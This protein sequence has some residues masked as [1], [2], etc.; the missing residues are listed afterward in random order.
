M[1]EL[2]RIE[3]ATNKVSDFQKKYNVNQK[4]ISYIIGKN[5]TL[6]LCL[7]VPLLLIGTVWTEFGAI[8]FHT[9]MIS[10]GIVT[11]MLLAVGEILMTRLG[12]DGGKMDLE[13]QEAKS[14][15]DEIVKRVGD[16]GA[17]LLD[18]F[19]DWQ[20]DVE[21]ERAVRVR[22]RILRMTPKMWAEVKDMSPA[23]LESH[24]GKRKAQKI[25]EIIDLKPIE[26]N[27]AILLYNG[28]YT[29]RGEIPE[30]GDAYINNKSHLITVALS[31]LFG[32]LLGLSILL[33]PTSDIS[34]ARVMYTAIKLAFLLYRMA[35]GYDRGAKAYNTIEVRRIQS[36]TN[37]LKQYLKFIEEKLYVKLGDKYGDL[38]QFVKAESGEE[39]IEKE[40]VA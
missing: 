33:Y 9:K 23:A 14:E 16:A 12:K 6:F 39:P 4:K 13:Y 27:S 21:L 8:V 1:D 10:E 29:E 24:F 15:F 17:L 5:L 34:F 28:E 2:E 32:G 7:L 38:A 26:L 31:W 25:Q 30:S 36:K 11:V 3:L 40:T 22:L 20:I 35:T 18:V 19:C 37:Y